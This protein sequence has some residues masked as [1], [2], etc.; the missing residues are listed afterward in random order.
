MSN[1]P[2]SRSRRSRMLNSP[3]PTW[4]TF[5]R[6]SS[7][8]GSNP[9]P[10]SVTVMQSVSLGPSVRIHHDSIDLRVLDHVEQELPDRFEEQRPHVFGG[11]NRP[12]GRQRA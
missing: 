3:H 6:S 5:V 7:F 9:R 8:V 11:R 2:P 12:A 4:L 1:R 10:S